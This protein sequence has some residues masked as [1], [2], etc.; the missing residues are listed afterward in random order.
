[1][2]EDPRQNPYTK[3]K[4]KTQRSETNRA[5]ADR[6]HHHGLWW[7]LWFDH[8]GSHGCGSRGLLLVASV[9][10]DFLFT[11]QFFVRL[12]CEFAFKKR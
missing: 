4:H 10:H 7:L 8:G 5:R 12:S 1:M 11:M 6:G 9:S 3:M 2:T